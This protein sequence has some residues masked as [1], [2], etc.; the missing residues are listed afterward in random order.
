MLVCGGVLMLSPQSE[1]E[2]LE[3]QSKGKFKI[4]YIN[5]KYIFPV[6]VIVGGISIEK[7]L[8]TF[9]LNVFDF[10][11]GKMATNL[12]MLIFLLLCIVMTVLSFLKNLSLIP[13][14]GLIS[15]CYLLTGMAVSN[16]IWFGV[17][18]FIGLVFYFCYGYKK[19]KLNIDA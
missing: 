2:T 6:L 19:S 17:W 18:L 15:C 12:P 13:L 10:S 3:R 7:F 1:A 4:P 16:W 14:L 11:D 8:P 5:S 9:Y